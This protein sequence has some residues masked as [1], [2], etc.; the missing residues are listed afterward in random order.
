MIKVTR[1]DGREYY[2]NPHQIELIELKPDTTIVMLSGKQH[3][4]REKIAEVLES[5]E[6]YRRRINPF[7][8]EE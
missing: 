7:I 4:V 5:I 8:N 3:I 6:T 2:L 1:L